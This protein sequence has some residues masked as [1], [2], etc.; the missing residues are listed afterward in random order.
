M[1][2]E[3]ER[4]C[5]EE[6][7]VRYTV[8]RT[9]VHPEH[10]CFPNFPKKISD[11]I[12]GLHLTFS[13]GGNGVCGRTHKI[14]ELGVQFLDQES[15][16]QFS[17]T[18]GDEYFPSAFSDAQLLICWLL[19]SRHESFPPSFSRLL[20][21]SCTSSGKWAC[22]RRP[23]ITTTTCLPQKKKKKGN[24]VFFEI[25]KNGSNMRGITRR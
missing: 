4:R 16:K 9:I 24:K 1:S 22:V 5:K 7:M 6:L 2:L 10:S 21:H 14:S 3:E 20:Y 13:T 23:P 19:T 18:D 8:N 12:F 15:M 17:W 25:I 11:F